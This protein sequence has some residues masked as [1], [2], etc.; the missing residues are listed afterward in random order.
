MKYGDEECGTCNVLCD[1]CE[2]S[3]EERK[4]AAMCCDVRCGGV[5][6]CEMC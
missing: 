4:K 5:M 1:C 6:W 2:M 3:E